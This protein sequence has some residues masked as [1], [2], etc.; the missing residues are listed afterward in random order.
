[1]ASGQQRHNEQVKQTLV[2]FMPLE[3]MLSDPQVR[4]LA[5]AAG[6]G[7]LKKIDPLL[8]QGV[9]VN[10]RAPAMPPRCAGQ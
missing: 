6:K 5:K 1:M 7:Q 4:A 10:A 9:D 8:A 3:T 2:K